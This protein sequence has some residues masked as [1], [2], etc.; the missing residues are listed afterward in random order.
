MNNAS[1]P[2]LKDALSGMLGHRHLGRTLI[3]TDAGANLVLGSLSLLSPA[4]W[5]Y[6]GLPAEARKLSG[7]LMIGGGMAQGAI[8]VGSNA[9]SRTGWIAVGSNL[10][11]VRSVAWAYRHSRSPLRWFLTLVVA[12]DF[13]MAAGKA[14][15]IVKAGQDRSP[16]VSGA[17]PHPAPKPA[18]SSA[19]SYA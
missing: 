7:W 14:Y 2:L 10:A 15:G 19:E 3:G 16:Q 1:S 12:Y 4:L 9:V 17:F 13:L 18:H 5:K 11:W 8:V 6:F